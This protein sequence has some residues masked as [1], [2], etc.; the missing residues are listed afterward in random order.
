[1]RSFMCIVKIQHIVL[2]DRRIR[3]ANNRELFHLADP[4][5]AALCEVLV[6]LGDEVVE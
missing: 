1:M 4:Q 5:L 2:D 3:E 6:H